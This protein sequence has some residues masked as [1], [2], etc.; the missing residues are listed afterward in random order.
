MGTISL[1]NLSSL[2]SNWG[3]SPD[4]PIMFVGHGSPMNAI[5]KNNYTKTW[6]EVGKNLPTPNAI[7]VVSAHWETKGTKVTAMPNPK[8]IH[9]FYGFPKELFDAEYNAPGDPELASKIVREQS[10]YTIEEDHKW[11]LDHG[12]WSILMPMYPDAKIPVLQLSLDKHLSPEQH[13][14]LAHQLKS[15]RQKGVLVVGSGNIVHNL[16]MMRFNQP[17]YDWANEFDRYV[18]Q[19]LNKKDFKSLIDY[20]SFGTAAQLSVPTNEHYLPMLYML[21]MSDKSEQM[22]YFN[23]KMDLGSVSMRSFIIG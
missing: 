19:K 11:G 4:M 13:F 7:L 5:E 20:Q 14:D 8:T 23:N 10:K 16:R 21:G 3:N 22:H 1:S 6:A 12:T 2:A 9:D 17:A 15:L 18:E